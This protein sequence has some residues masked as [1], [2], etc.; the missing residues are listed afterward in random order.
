MIKELQD[1]NVSLQFFCFSYPEGAD[2]ASSEGA[3]SE[4]GQ[5]PAECGHFGRGELFHL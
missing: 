5:K 3:S 1:M 2:G 4:G